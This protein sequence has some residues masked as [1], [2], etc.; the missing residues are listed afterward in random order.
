M[1]KQVESSRVKM[2]WREWQLTQMHWPSLGLRDKLM[3]CIKQRE[4]KRSS[5]CSED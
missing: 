1:M 2:K 5:E 3:I 4:M